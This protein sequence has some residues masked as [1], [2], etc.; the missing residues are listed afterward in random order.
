[1]KIGCFHIIAERLLY[2]GTLPEDFV[3]NV[4]FFSTRKP[5]SL[6]FKYQSAWFQIS[7]SVYAPIDD[8]INTNFQLSFS[9]T[10]LYTGNE[11]DP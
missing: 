9:E 4:G 8:T 7:A 3:N 5:F 6:F 11:G 2:S 10:V 1:M